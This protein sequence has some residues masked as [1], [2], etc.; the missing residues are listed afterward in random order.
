MCYVALPSSAKTCSCV[1]VPVARLFLLRRSHEKVWVSLLQRGQLLVLHNGIHQ[2]MFQP[3]VCQEWRARA[4]AF[5][6]EAHG[7]KPDTDSTAANAQGA[8]GAVSAAAG[9]VEALKQV[10][11]KGQSSSAETPVLTSGGQNGVPGV[12]TVVANVLAQFW[13]Q[14]KK[15]V[16]PSS[17]AGTSDG[18]LLQAGPQSAVA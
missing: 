7:L 11:S 4:K 6:A 17:T 12:G 13:P 9:H 8:D 14:K 16:A 1:L 2:F 15:H 18:S 3:G 5:T 10:D